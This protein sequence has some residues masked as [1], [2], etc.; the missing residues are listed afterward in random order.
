MQPHEPAIIRRALAADLAAIAV[1]LEEVDELHRTA[2]PWLFRR[3]DGAEQTAFRDDFVSKPDH[4]TFLA[5]AADGTFAGVLY[6]FLRP[7]PRAPI[8]RPAVVAE[9]D[10]LAVKTSFRRR[11][12][13]KQLVGA[14]LEWA[15]RA[16]A[17]R[18]ELGVFD[19][20]ETARAF[21]TSLGFQVLSY[22][23]VR[24]SDRDT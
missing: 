24:H 21:W 8:V 5:V 22:R 17:S 15:R 10:A 2:H 9:L 11:G 3:L 18:T 13:G 4:A 12:I 19:F 20:N 23:M 7:P 14:A 6:A 16:G 1:L